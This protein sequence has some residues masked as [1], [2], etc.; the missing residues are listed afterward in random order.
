MLHSVVRSN[1][2]VGVLLLGALVSTFGSAWVLSAARHRD[3]WQATKALLEVKQAPRTTEYPGV[4]AWLWQ[5][6]RRQCEAEPSAD[7][8]ADCVNVLRP[9]TIPVRLKPLEA[10]LAPAPPSIEK[11]Q[12]LESRR[13]GRLCIAELEVNDHRYVA[14]R[15]VLDSNCEVPPAGPLIDQAIAL[16][17]ARRVPGRMTVEPFGNM[18]PVRAYVMAQDGTLISGRF[19]DRHLPHGQ[20]GIEYQEFSRTADNLAVPSVTSVNSFFPLIKRAGYAYTG[21]YADVAGL[22]VVATGMTQTALPGFGEAVI[23]IDVAL[24]IDWIENIIVERPKLLP[25]DLAADGKSSPSWE[26]V[27]AQAAARGAEDLARLARRCSGLQREFDTVAACSPDDESEGALLAATLIGV[28]SEG[29]PVT[30]WLIAWMS[31]LRTSFEIAQYLPAVLLAFAALV[32]ALRDRQYRALGAESASQR[33]Q[34]GQLVDSLGTALIVIDPNTD[35]VRF[36]NA[37]AQ[38]L[39]IELNQIFREL[40]E[41]ED[42]RL[43]DQSNLASGTAERAY[44]VRLQSTASAPRWAIVRSTAL[45][46]PLSVLG[47]R[48]SD[49]LG[50]M[51]LLNAAEIERL[52]AS[53]ELSAMHEERG[54]LSS[55]ITHGVA[56]L[57]RLLASDRG[58]DEQL[59]RWLGPY[60]M[61]RVSVLADLLSGW[62]LPLDEVRCDELAVAKQSVQSMLEAFQ[63]LATGVAANRELRKSLQWSN[64]VL[65]K[66][67]PGAAPFHFDLQGWPDDLHLTIRIEGAETFILDELLVNTFKHG[68]PGCPPTL[69]ARLIRGADRRWIEF[70]LRNEVRS[71][72][73]VRIT[74]ADHRYGG[75]T[76]VEEACR[77]LRWEFLQP[78]LQGEIYV[79]RWRARTIEA[80]E[81]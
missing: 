68:K 65:S 75:K 43:Y 6:L 1:L 37:P 63:T 79:V 44:A 50:L 14:T 23:A 76:L 34:W 36:R 59:R 62:E 48:E 39:G 16:L 45:A 12:L 67:A 56:H 80:A 22:G 26:W 18:E 40:V 35:R 30:R 73:D 61:R 10:F 57:T 4:T 20:R 70:E 66:L 72:R 81:D 7:A 29:P 5:L 32:Y 49:R 31:P 55:L 51:S 38:Q 78:E 8:Q 28:S 52:R 47:A 77:R 46:T 17:D 60:L 19:S 3:E 69:S 11:P 25:L 13:A 9:G 54:K 24:G 71:T 42:R 21:T 74:G 58:L 15:P 27:A 2:I 33:R 53:L 64:G 41:D